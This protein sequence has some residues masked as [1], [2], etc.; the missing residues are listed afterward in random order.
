M[1]IHLNNIG[2]LF[3]VDYPIFK[4]DKNFNNKY[5]HVC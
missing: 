2:I 4:S 3:A 1:D 5:C